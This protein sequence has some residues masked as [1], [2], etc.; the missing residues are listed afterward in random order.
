MPRKTP[1][2][3][4]IADIIV[5]VSC[6]HCDSIVNSPGFTK[7]AGWDKRDVETVGRDGEVAC[8]NKKCKRVFPLPADLFKLLPAA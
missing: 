7:S 1:A 5:W 6:P 8:V 4:Q 2:K 3:Y